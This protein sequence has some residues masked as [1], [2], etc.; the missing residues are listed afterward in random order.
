MKNSWQFDIVTFLN[1]QERFFFRGTDNG[2]F[3]RINSEHIIFGGFAGAA[4]GITSGLFHVIE[5]Q[6]LAANE[7]FRDS[8]KKLQSLTDV[9]VVELEYA[10][11]DLE[12]VSRR[13]SK[14]RTR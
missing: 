2:S 8:L 1:Q 13:Y 10:N 9:D 6:E 4:D 11:R 12:A 7:S 14:S 3:I 5:K